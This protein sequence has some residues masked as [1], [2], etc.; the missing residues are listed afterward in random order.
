MN[1][2]TIRQLL[3]LTDGC[4]NAGEDPAAMAAYALQCGITVNVIG[5]VDDSGRAE[6]LQEI[7]AIARSGGGESRIVRA[8][9]LSETVVNVTRQA[10]TGTIYS[11]INQELREILNN[12]ARVE[13]LPPEKRSEIAEKVEEI[14]EE[15]ALKLLIL[16]DISASMKK[17]L[18]AVKEALYDL[19]VTM[20]SRSGDSSFSLWTFPGK[21]SAAEERISWT[22]DAKKLAESFPQLASGGITPTGPAIR[23]ALSSFLE[24][25]E[26]DEKT[27]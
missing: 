1:M 5:I 18:P 4:S 11:I 6:G 3:L 21:Y 17:K 19:S 13:S 24:M 23:Q 8:Q 7:E 15:A 20:Q 22:S 12:D 10:M 16:T 2:G 27:I 25:D 9:S 14:S 26:Y